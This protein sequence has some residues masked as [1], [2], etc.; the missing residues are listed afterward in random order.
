VSL[1][2]IEAMAKALQVQPWVL[3]RFGGERDTVGDPFS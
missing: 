2:N 3:L 1:S